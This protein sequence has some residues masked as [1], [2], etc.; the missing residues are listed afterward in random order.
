[1]Y[2]LY[3]LF[4]WQMLHLP[5]YVIFLYLLYCS[6]HYMIYVHLAQRLFNETFF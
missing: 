1:M 5:A 6:F 3:T 2:V 4:Y